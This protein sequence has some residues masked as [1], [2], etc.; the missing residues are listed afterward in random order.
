MQKNK[1]IE[2]IVIFKY[3]KI[4]ISFQLVN[5]IHP[6]KNK[7]YSLLIFFWNSGDEFS[8]LKQTRDFYFCIALQNQTL[9]EPTHPWKIMKKDICNSTFFKI[10]GL[11]KTFTHL[12]NI[13]EKL[14]ENQ[15]PKDRV[16]ERLYVFFEVTYWHMRVFITLS[17][18]EVSFFYGVRVVGAWYSFNESIETCYKP[19]SLN[20]SVKK[21][22]CLTIG[23]FSFILPRTWY[24]YEYYLYVC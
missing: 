21:N 4:R 5:W 24:S 1:N 7:I 13:S 11:K 14:Q 8:Q 12:L 19:K 3:N 15:S 17:T 10:L 23:T 6:L 16:L 22:P 2:I 18:K 20:K 9:Y